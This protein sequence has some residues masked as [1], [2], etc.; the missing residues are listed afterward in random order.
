M[1]ELELEG[2]VVLA[3]GE[4]AFSMAFHG[5]LGL[6]N[7]ARRGEGGWRWRMALAEGVLNFLPHVIVNSQ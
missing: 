4:E 2:Q 7:Q 5:T 6:A 1:C 3:H